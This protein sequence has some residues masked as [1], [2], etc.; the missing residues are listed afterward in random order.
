MLLRTAVHH[1]CLLGFSWDKN[2]SFVSLLRMFVRPCALLATSAAVLETF[3]TVPHPVLEIPVWCLKSPPSCK[4]C[5]NWDL[6][7]WSQPQNLQ[8]YIIIFCCAA[9]M[10]CLVTALLL[11]LRSGHARDRRS[12]YCH[13]NETASV[14]DVE[15]GSAQP[16]NLALHPPS[17]ILSLRCRPYFFNLLLVVLV[18]S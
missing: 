16:A 14:E 8:S 9:I 11:A 6:T 18:T 13:Q 2:H 12:R 10:G 4:Y 17:R 3:I 5:L 1:I 7:Y 15:M